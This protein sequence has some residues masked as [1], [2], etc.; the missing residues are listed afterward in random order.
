MIKTILSTICT[1]Y[2]DGISIQ[3][4]SDIQYYAIKLFD[5]QCYIYGKLH[6][7]LNK[8]VINPY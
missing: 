1:F 2:E 3:I 6:D 5:T 4:N 7:K 8:I